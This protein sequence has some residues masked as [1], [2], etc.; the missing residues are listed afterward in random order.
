MS[1]SGYPDEIHYEP[2]YYGRGVNLWK[3]FLDNRQDADKLM[4][5]LNK[6]YKYKQRSFARSLGMT[7]HLIPDKFNLRLPTVINVL[8][9]C[10]ASVVYGPDKVMG[11]PSLAKGTLSYPTNAGNAE[12]LV[13]LQTKFA[14]QEQVGPFL[15]SLKRT[16]PD[17]TDFYR[18]HRNDQLFALELLT[19]VVNYG[20]DELIDHSEHKL[21]KYEDWYD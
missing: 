16:Y 3:R 15:A 4:G 2:E 8:R 14:R 7:L 18:M 20:L 6:Y 1:E 5:H 17:G 9:Y 10:C 19:N 12:N 11:N 21:G 13:A